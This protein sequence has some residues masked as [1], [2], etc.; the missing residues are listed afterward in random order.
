YDGF[1]RKTKETRAD[2]TYTTWAYQLCTDAGMSCPGPIAGATITW[3]AIEQSFAANATPSAPEKRQYYDT[4]NRAVRVQTQGY[5]G[6]GAGTAPTLVQ[7]TEY[8]ALGRVARKSNVYQLT[9]GTAYWG[10]YTYDVLGRVT[11]EESPDPDAPG[12]VAVTTISFTGLSTTVTNSKNQ[13]KTSTRNAQGQVAQVTDAQ[14]QTVNYSYDA[15]G[16]LTQTNAAGSITTVVYSQRGQKISMADPAMGA[17]E[18][19]YNVFGEL[20]WQRDSLGQTVSM[21]YDALGRMTQRTE[22][23]LVSQWSYD[24]KFDNS[25]CGKGVGKLCEAVSDNGYQRVHTYDALGRPSATSTVMDN[26]ASPAITSVVYDANTGRLAQRTWPTGY[27]ASYVYSATGYLKQV[28]GGGTNG[29]TQTV[30]YEVLAVDAQ[31]HITQYK[32]GNQVTT[33]K[34]Y[35]AATG[36]LN[37]QTAT[38]DGQSTGNVLNQSYGYDSLG[39]LTTRADNTAGVGTQESFSYDSLNRLSLYTMLGGAVSPPTSTEVL[40]DAR[41][42]I[43]YKSDVGRYWYDGQRPN[44]MTNVTLETAPGAQ[45]AFTGTR[46]LVYTFDDYKPTAQSVNGVTVGNGNLEYTVSL[47]TPNNRHTYRGETYTSFNM[48]ATITFGNMSGSTAGPVDRNLAFVYGPEHQRIKQTVVGGPKPGTTWYLNG[49]D[50]LGLSF[51]KELL[52]TGI[53]ENKHYVSAGGLVFAMFVQRTGTLGSTAPTAT[54]YFHHDHLG[55]MVA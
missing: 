41:G 35:N 9:G 23:D 12:G 45:I 53:T 2:A 15:L 11:R 30:S 46:Q 34:A 5:D 42:N 25:A 16:H 29:F 22:P 28:N 43:A 36:K 55:S 18:Y 10:S 37:G 21:A 26:P 52:A 51:E 27:Q 33:V 50:S 38:K 14:G 8:D 7:D 44:R 40:Y 19:R 31:G 32:Q 6:G 20:V 49:E 24:K 4:L 17:W 39:N 13:T 54:N 48:P 1:G 47:D 3:L